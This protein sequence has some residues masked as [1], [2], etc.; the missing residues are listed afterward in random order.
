LLLIQRV[1]IMAF[2]F[3]NIAMRKA[4]FSSVLAMPAFRSIGGNLFAN[5][6]MKIDPMRLQR[7]NSS[8]ELKKKHDRGLQSI[9]VCL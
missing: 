3:I 1:V 5:L 2:C 6:T 7:M 8:I 9:L 4:S